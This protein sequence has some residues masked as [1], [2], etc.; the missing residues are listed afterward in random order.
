M[1]MKWMIFRRMCNPKPIK[2]YRIIIS[3]YTVLLD[4]TSPIPWHSNAWRTWGTV[5]YP[6][7]NS[8]VVV[9]ITPTSLCT[10]RR[11]NGAKPP[12]V[13]S[14]WLSILASGIIETRGLMLISRLK[15]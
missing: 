8:E 12:A 1:S 7:T 9:L 11:F 6:L 4:V 14:R 13:G 3:I 15:N 10:H 5:R 2:R